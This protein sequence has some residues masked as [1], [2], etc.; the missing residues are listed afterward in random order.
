MNKRPSIA[1]SLV[2][3]DGLKY[4]PEC[5]ETIQDYYNLKEEG[6]DFAAAYM[7]VEV[8]KDYYELINKG[9]VGGEV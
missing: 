8:V 1:E 2:V 6:N 3:L 7:V 4:I 9:V 5:K